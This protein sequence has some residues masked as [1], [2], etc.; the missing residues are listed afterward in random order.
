MFGVKTKLQLQIRKLLTHFNGLVLQ[1]DFFFVTSFILH[2]G[3][4][5]K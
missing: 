4:L 2:M 1:R 5:F 3:N